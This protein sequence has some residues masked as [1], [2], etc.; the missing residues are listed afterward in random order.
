[1]FNRSIVARLIP[2]LLRQLPGVLGRVLR[3]RGILTIELPL[4]FGELLL[5]E[6]Q[7]PDR[8]LRPHR[9]VLLDVERR[10]RVGHVRSRLAESPVY[11][12]VKGHRLDLAAAPVRDPTD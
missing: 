9:L 1:V 6:R 5:E 11:L 8:R 12:S 3:D 10:N 7:R 2:H 4:R